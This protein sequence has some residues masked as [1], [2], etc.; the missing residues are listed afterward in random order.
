MNTANPYSD[1]IKMLKDTLVEQGCMIGLFIYGS[2]AKG[3]FSPDSAIDLFIIA[4]DTEGV[5]KVR[6]MI[7]AIEASMSH[8]L[9][10][11]IWTIEEMNKPDNALVQ[12]VFREGKLIYWNSLNDFQAN[13]VFKVRPH[14][15]FTFELS[16]LPQNVKARF[17]YQLYGKKTI[18]GLLAQMDGKRLTKSCFYV[19]FGKKY[20]ISRFLD[21][22]DIKH[23][24]TECWV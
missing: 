19:P 12:L 13:Q 15:I 4:N 16:N 1:T 3:D 2:F 23:V 8:T 11:T 18:T 20:K 14:T 21:K 7:K 24:S 22:F 9:R 5:E 17:N 6:E 10:P